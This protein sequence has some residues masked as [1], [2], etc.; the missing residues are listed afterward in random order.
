MNERLDSLLRRHE[1][2]SRLIQDPELVKDQNRYRSAMKEYSQLSEIA[3]A[4]GEIADLSA[5]LQDAKALIQEE[6]DP[7]IKELARE[8][9]KELEVR[10]NDAG[11][12]LKFL[13]IPKD[14]LDEKNIIMEI[15]AGTGGEEAALFA[16]DLFRL[17][18]RFA[19]TKGWKFEIMN[20]N[21]TELGGLKEIVFSISG[22][23]V[24]EN[25]RYESGVHRVQRVPATE[26]S[27]RIH[28]SAVTVAVLPE[29]DETE[30]E[31]RPEDLR[32]DVMR[33]GGPGGQCVNTTDSAVRI[34]H[35]PSG[36]VVHCQDEKSQI[37]NKAKAMRILRAR[38]YE[39]EEAK[40][41]S[42]RAE[43]RKNQVGTGD[44]SERIRTYNFPDNRL[45]DH[46]IG[47]TLYKL[48]RIM[49]G[50]IEEVFDALKLSAREELL[51]ATAS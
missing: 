14:P 5:Q 2:L 4:N 34:T 20:S 6:K 41:A 42:E 26:A 27:G 12:R 17:Y 22:K 29:A 40:A 3:A 36:I 15:R 19:E 47:L 21:E 32:I 46:R 51:K 43:A 31:I 1:E 10:I 35:I 8:E 44:R 13:L 7:D 33:A 9:I 24:Y 48:D 50:E 30:I 23:N 38:I 25:L 28:T 49:E 39:M 45:T 11:D 16:A 18:S 37:K